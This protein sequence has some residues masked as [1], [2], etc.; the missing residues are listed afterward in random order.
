MDGHFAFPSVGFIPGPDSSD[1]HDC[2]LWISP[3]IVGSFRMLEFLWG[4][5]IK[6]LYRLPELD[7]DTIRLTKRLYTSFSFATFSLIGHLGCGAW[8]NRVPISMDEI[9]FNVKQLRTSF[10]PCG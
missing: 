1:F 7:E 8:M 3:G 10:L 6:D 4:P 2:F 5:S 9:L